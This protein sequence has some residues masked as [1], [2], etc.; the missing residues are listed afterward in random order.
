MAGNGRATPGL[1]DFDTTARTVRWTVRGN[2]LA[3]TA[4][5]NKMVFAL[6]S[7]LTLDVYNEA[8]GS[9]ASSWTALSSSQQWSSNILLTNN[10]VFV[11]T[12]SIRYAIDPGTHLPVWSHPFAGKLSRSA[13][14]ILY[15]NSENNIL[16]VNVQ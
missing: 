2:F 1:T 4:Y 15:I 16:A 9:L 13:N 6:Q 14:G 8:D 3:G 12:D 7:P 5:D 11:S 10:I